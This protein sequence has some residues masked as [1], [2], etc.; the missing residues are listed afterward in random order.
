MATR[1]AVPPPRAAPRVRAVPAVTRAIAILRLLGR[2]PQPL[3]LKAIAEELGI[4]PSTGLHILRVLV[5]EG[6][7]KLDAA[8]KRYGLGT[9]M[10]A[11]ARSVIQNDPFPLLVQ[12]VLDRL[13]AAW[14]LTTIGVEVGDADHMLVVAL[15]RSSAPFRLHVDV[16]SRFPLLISATGR[17]VAALHDLPANELERRFR[18]LRWDNPPAMRAWTRDLRA[19]RRNGY[20]IDPG[21][22]IAGVTLVAVPVFGAAG[23]M[24]HTLVAAGV[25]EQLRGPK[26]EELARALQ[27]EARSLSRLLGGQSEIAP[28]PNKR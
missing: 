13:S 2:S 21:H 15:A 8:T 28:E 4:V 24:T 26:A 7:V 14:H 25:T 23:T 27:A 3:P 17:L 10:L 20:S 22:Y 19:A 1:D 18:A 16:G 5:A 12:P 9:G 6:V 11:L